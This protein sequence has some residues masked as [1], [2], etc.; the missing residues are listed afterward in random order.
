MKTPTLKPAKNGQ[1]Y[2]HWT[3]N[4]RT[5]RKSMG[6][7]DRAEAERAFA[8]W[9]LTRNDLPAPERTLTVADV[10]AFYISKKGESHTAFYSWANLM[11]H[12]AALD[13]RKV[14]QKEVDAYVAARAA[15]EIGQHSKPST[16]RRELAVLVAAMNLGAHPLYALY[17]PS[18]LQPLLL[19]PDSDPR[20]RWLTVK[21][22][23]TL[24]LAAVGFRKEPEELCR[25]EI[26]LWLALETAARKQAILDLTWDRVDFAQGVIHYDVPGRKK[27]KKRR[28]SVPIS[29]SLRPVLERA[30]AQ[31]HGDLVMWHGADVWW[32]VQ[33]V[34]EVAGLKDVSPHVLR[35]TAATHM[36]RNGVSLWTVANILGNTMAVVEKTYAKWCPAEPERNVNLISNGALS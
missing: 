6:T 36:A 2:A 5:H 16:C 18:A 15:G 3:V 28:A 14:N 31:R 4:R 30:H 35:H 34:A 25:V 26:F 17:P 12:F 24:M 13:V 1:F 19:P 27:T 29:A 9:L 33:R 8:N 20:D 7:S 11:Q 23:Q 10:W 32:A 21:E 22:M